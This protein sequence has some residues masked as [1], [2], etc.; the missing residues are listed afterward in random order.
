MSKQLA[1][2]CHPMLRILRNPTDAQHL[3]ASDWEEVLSHARQTRLGGR[4]WHILEVQG[5]VHHLPAA[6]QRRLFSAF[7]AGEHHRQRILW[8]VNRVRWALRCERSRFILLKGGAYAAANLDIAKGRDVRDLDILVPLD[9]L[10]GTENSLLA[11]GWRHVISD[12]YDQS[13]YRLWMH[14]LPPLEHPDRG[15]ELDIHHSIV[16]RWSP[17]SADMASLHEAAIALDNRGTR[18][19]A[20]VDMTLHCA[21]HL[22]QAGEIRGALRDLVDFKALL[23]EFSTE[24]GFWA[25]LAPRARMFRLERPLFYA[26]RYASLLL[27]AR[28]PENAMR[29]T[30]R[31]TSPMLLFMDLLI[32]TALVPPRSP[33]EGLLAQAS[34]FCLYIRSHWLRM[35]P[36]RLV[37]HL[38]RK[39]VRR[40][41]REP[42]RKGDGA[43]ARPFRR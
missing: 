13:Y 29:G 14:E 22:F 12:D 41:G 4:F 27:G 11:H 32:P 7:L 21:V 24:P 8:E 31:P 28:V 42:H 1:I 39:L 3:S 43:L 34:G 38:T 35:A 33:W 10:P 23:D 9:R 5:L 6:A 36:W 17:A 37:K 18:V 30:A 26:L 20:P 40:I 15:M 19:L 25:G 2:S 16:P